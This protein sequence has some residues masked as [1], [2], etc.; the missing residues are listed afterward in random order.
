MEERDVIIVGTGPAGLSAAM[1]AQ[2][3]GW[4]TLVPEAN[5]VGGQGVSYYAKHDFEK[6]AG[7][8]E[9]NAVANFKRE[10]QI[11]CVSMRPVTVTEAKPGLRERAEGLTAQPIYR[12]S[13]EGRPI[14]PLRWFSLA[15]T[16]AQAA[17]FLKVPPRRVRMPRECR[18]CYALAQNSQQTEEIAS[19]LDT[20]FTSSRISAMLAIRLADRWFE[21]CRWHTSWAGIGLSRLDI[22]S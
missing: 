1:F 9:T 16:S 18:E 22:S 7:K 11:S 20:R 10:L 19:F 6:L 17:R 15:S 4:S 3:D 13:W 8:A 21:L 12:I 2:L 5:W 14:R